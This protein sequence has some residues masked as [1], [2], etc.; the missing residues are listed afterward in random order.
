M[1]LWK[2]GSELAHARRLFAPQPEKKTYYFAFGANLSRD[3]LKRRKIKVFEESDY[4]LEDARLKFTRH[5][6]YKDHGFASADPHPGGRVFG[7][8]YL[9]FES[10]AKRMD[11]FEGVPFLKAHEKVFKEEDGRR[12]FYYR[13]S[14]AIDGL[15]PTDEYLSYI[16]QAYERMQEIPEDY[17]DDLKQISTLKELRPLDRANL[18]ITRIERWPRVCWPLLIFYERVLQRMVRFTWNKSI[19]QWMI[20]VDD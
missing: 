15:K 20:K 11:Y 14:L 18:F 5:G 10:D 1:I 17:L 16:I 13:T 4:C 12:F 6:F 3:V 19:V 8:I 9:I 2:I 7:K